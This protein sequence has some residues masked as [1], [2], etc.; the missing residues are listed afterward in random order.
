MKLPKICCAASTIAIAVALTSMS[1]SALAQSEATDA[2]SSGTFAR[3]VITVT[4]QRREE[5]ITDVPVSITAFGQGDAD[6]RSIADIGDV[7]RI[8]PNL[9]FSDFGNTIRRVAIRGVDSSAGSGTTGIYIN[10]VPI[11]VR[12]IG[13]NAFDSFPQVF[14]LERIEVLRGPQGT[15]FGA[16]SQG[17]TVRFIT[18]EPSLDEYSGYS[19]AIVS[20]TRRGDVSYEVGAAVGGPI[21][22]DRIAFRVSAWYRDEGGYIDRLTESGAATASLEVEEEDANSTESVAIRG[23]FKIAVTDNF[24]ISPS[25]FYQKE[26]FNDTN[27]LWLEDTGPSALTTSFADAYVVPATFSNLDEGL[28][29]GGDPI[30]Q[31][32][33]DEFILP[34]IKAEWDMGFG[35]LTVVGSYYDREQILNDDFTT[36]DQVLFTAVTNGAIAGVSPF[37]FSRPVLPGQQALGFDINTQEN[38]AVE[39]RMQSNPDEFGRLDWLVG[40]FYSENEQTALQQVGDDFLGPVLNQQFIDLFGTDV[41]GLFTG[42][43]GGDPIL[44]F[45]GIPL[46]NGNLIFDN[47]EVAN[48]RQIAGFAQFDY[49]IIDNVTITAGVRVSNTEFSIE[50]TVGGPVLGPFNSDFV[51]QKETPITPK[52]A[53]SWQPD[54]GQLYYASASQGFRIGGANAAVGLPCGVGGDGMGNPAPGTALGVQGLTDRPL[55]FDS[56]DLWSYEVGA[57]NTLFG[58]RLQTEV[59]Y[60]HIDWQNIQQNIQLPACGFRYFNNV[61]SA[62]IDGFEIA[63]GLN[64]TENLFVSTAIGYTDARFTETS[65]ATDAAEAL[66]AAPLVSEGDRLGG[67]PLTVNVVAEYSFLDPLFGRN[68]YL[69]ADWDR[70]G[71][72]TGRT[73]VLNGDNGGFDPTA[74]P[75]PVTNFVNLRLAIEPTDGFE[76]SV[77]AT[78]LLDSAPLLFRQV[79]P[80]STLVRGQTFRPRTVGLRGIYRF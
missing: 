8:V 18:P 22:E 35:A 30:Q 7:A 34:S 16:G 36:F 44:N 59:A 49:E 50:N 4:A 69:R 13:F 25:I 48:D 19:R 38:W 21:V 74:V 10:D 68:S 63:A 1:S 78:N 55:S 15:L 70:T 64:I 52:F 28:F 11:Q 33:S 77:F 47:F 71:H 58:G 46:V 17:G 12:Q 2:E 61:G 66:G 65:F 9:N 40:F 41:S 26:D 80:S 45:F 60:F 24:T 3:D 42:V 73:P 39:A 5:K 62:A 51:S 43:P 14:D 29:V 32:G 72:E 27:V 54:D 75:E 20:T 56:D 67:P 57:K 6:R 31:S 79:Q 53:I 37:G 76:L 23:D